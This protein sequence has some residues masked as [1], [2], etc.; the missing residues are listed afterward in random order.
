MPR[1]AICNE[2]YGDWP[3]QAALA[4]ISDAG[5]HGVEI[6][7]FTLKPDPRELT[8]DD[9]K[10]IGDMVRFWDLDVVGLRA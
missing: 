5:Y 3:L 6:A 2:T 4:D 9:A 1:F 7:P 8:E 10:R